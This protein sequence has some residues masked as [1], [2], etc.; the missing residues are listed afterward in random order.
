MRSGIPDGHRLDT[1][2]VGHQSLLKR[3]RK[4]SEV[5]RRVGLRVTPPPVLGPFRGGMGEP[6]DS[7]RST[8]CADAASRGRAR[9]PPRPRPTRHGDLGGV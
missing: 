5:P 3:P 1:P 4:H 7:D 6:M 2:P 9:A 8:P